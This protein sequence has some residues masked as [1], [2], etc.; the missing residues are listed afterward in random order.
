MSYEILEEGDVQFQGNS[1]VM[2]NF[3][4]VYIK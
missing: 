4:D 3:I 2:S 1:K